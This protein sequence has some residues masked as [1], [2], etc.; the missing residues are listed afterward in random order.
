MINIKPT[1]YSTLV[2]VLDNVH[3][4]YP[5]SFS[6]FPVIAYCEEDNHT[7]IKTDGRERIAYVRYKIDIWS[8]KSTSSLTIDVDNAISLLGLKRTQCIDIVEQ[9]LKHKVLRYE[10]YIDVD[11]LRLYN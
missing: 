7:H 11:K 9:D 1:I 5:S 4:G 3:D 8:D 2:S 10:G 6:N